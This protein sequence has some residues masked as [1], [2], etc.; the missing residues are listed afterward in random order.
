[1]LN[2]ANLFWGCVTVVFSIWLLADQYWNR[3]DS[4]IQIANET[5]RTLDDLLALAEK[6]E[7]VREIEDTID[8]I[9]GH[10]LSPATEIMLR[11]LREERRA[12]LSGVSHEL[13]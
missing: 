2:E 7:R 4:H 11:D 8:E 9:T 6:L 5:E 10:G 3:K 12:I 1:M 13:G